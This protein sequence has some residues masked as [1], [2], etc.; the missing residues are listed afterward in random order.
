MV[1][2]LLFDWTPRRLE[3]ALP[4]LRFRACGAQVANRVEFLVQGE[5]L[6]EERR[7]HFVGPDRPSSLSFFLPVFLSVFRTR[8]AKPLELEEVRDPRD[9]LF[10]RPIRVV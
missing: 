3:S 7:G 1:G 4:F 6:L 8:A 9:R 10:Q 2:P 5:D